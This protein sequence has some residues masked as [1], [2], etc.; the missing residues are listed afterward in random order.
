LRLD[1]DFMQ[2]DFS[3]KRMEDYLVQFKN[4]ALEKRVKLLINAYGL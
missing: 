4:K 1:E 2:D 3:I